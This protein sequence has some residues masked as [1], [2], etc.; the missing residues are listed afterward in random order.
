MGRRGEAFEFTG[1]IFKVTAD[2]SGKALHSAA[3]EK[4]ASAKVAMAR[5]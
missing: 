3:E 2:V 5:Q 4:D 1:T